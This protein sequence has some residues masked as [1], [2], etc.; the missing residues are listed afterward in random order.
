MITI[1]EIKRAVANKSSQVVYYSEKHLWWTH[2]RK[3]LRH[4]M[5]K[6][7]VYIKTTNRKLDGKSCCPLGYPIHEA[8]ARDWITSSLRH[9]EWFGKHGIEAFLFS[10]HQNCGNFYSNKWEE[11]NKRIDFVAKLDELDKENNVKG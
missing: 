2:S 1:E 11:Y 9:P 8:N 4:A 6:A 7:L 5:K 10:H 3:D